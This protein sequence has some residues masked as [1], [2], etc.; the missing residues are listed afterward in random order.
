[1]FDTLNPTEMSLLSSLQ[2]YYCH[3]EYYHHHCFD[4]I[5]TQI[6]STYYQCFIILILN[7]VVIN[8]FAASTL[9]PLRSSP[10][11]PYLLLCLKILVCKIELV[12][13]IHHKN[14]DDQKTCLQG[15][16]CWD[17]WWQLGA[18]EQPKPTKSS[19]QL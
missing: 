14:D 10:S 12:H 5:S 15:W 3:I 6:L 7:A 16:A 13:H 2:C 1:M 9:S 4:E 17:Q 18:G 8:T 11:L 19:C